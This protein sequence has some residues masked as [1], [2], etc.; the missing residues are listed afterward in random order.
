[1]YS[2]HSISIVHVGHVYNKKNEKKKQED[3]D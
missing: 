3:T 1:M 2:D